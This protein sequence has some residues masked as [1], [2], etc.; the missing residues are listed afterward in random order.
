MRWKSCWIVT[1]IVTI[2]CLVQGASAKTTYKV[3]Y[4]F[5]GG[6]DGMYPSA[7]LVP[8]AAGSLYGV[9]AGGGLSRNGGCGTVFELRR[10][11]RGWAEKVLYRF[12]GGADGCYP[13]TNL[14]IDG[15]GSLYGTTYSG[16]TGDCF[17]KTCGTVFEL[18]PASKGEWKET[19]IHRFAGG[20]D[21]ELPNAGVVLDAA[22]NIYG[23]T[24][25]GGGSSCNCG[26]VFE[27]S[28]QAGGG[29]NEK[30][31]HTFSGADGA[32]PCALAFD[33]AGDLY[34][35]AAVGGNYDVGVAFELSPASGRG[36]NENTI[37]TFSSDGEGPVSLAFDGRNLYGATIVGGSGN[38]GTIFELKHESNGSSTHSVL[39]GFT[40]GKDG[41]Y[42]GGLLRFD[43]SGN[44]YG[45][46]SGDVTCTKGNR[47]ACGNVFELMSQSHQPRRR[48]QVLH[49][50][51]GGS[52]GAGPSGPAF[53]ENGDI[54]GV[55]YTGG[56]GNCSGGGCG[57]VFEILRSL[58]PASGDVSWVF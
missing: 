29:W 33:G 56:D 58:L 21:G 55:A 45:S 54:F 27:L 36:W 24:E 2:L 13:Y 46:T 20:K 4:N 18:T 42:P 28:P 49:T 17:G 44:L 34:G 22:G 52:N 23:T 40:G 9:T 43:K 39:H 38:W 47:W 48:L 1:T 50:F 6:R 53:D 5:Q 57:I 19:V 41:R 12:A 32:D 14:A 51:T 35:V 30:I 15:R 25:D 16:G 11:N 8:D 10:V 37:Y 3:L 31:I 7:A 26:V